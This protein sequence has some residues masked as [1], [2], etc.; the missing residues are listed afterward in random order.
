MTPGQLATYIKSVHKT[1]PPEL[2]SKLVGRYGYEHPEPPEPHNHKYW[3]Y[4]CFVT[5]ENLSSAERWCYANF[6][7]RNWRNR[8]QFFGF[9][10]KEDW[11]W[12]KLKWQ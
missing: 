9:K 5:F 3:P 6:K 12:F 1:L 8:G 2:A 10:R 4:Q 11:L 7:S